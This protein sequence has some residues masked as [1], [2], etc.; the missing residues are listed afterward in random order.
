M[1][2]L[3][4]GAWH[5]VDVMFLVAGQQS[6][7]HSIGDMVGNVLRACLKVHDCITHAS[8]FAFSSTFVQIHN[9]SV[10]SHGDAAM[11]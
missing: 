6:V 9:V 11:A 8:T 2:L 5:V 7:I 1:F 4:I 3:R 10:N